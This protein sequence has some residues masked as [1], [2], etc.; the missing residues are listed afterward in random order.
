MSNN[1][2]VGAGRQSHTASDGTY[3]ERRY[4]YLT[5]EMWDSLHHISR[6]SGLTASQYLAH[7]IASTGK[8]KGN[9]NESVH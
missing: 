4:C 2:N 3:L 7:I 8:P 5:P 6:E 1:R 9:N